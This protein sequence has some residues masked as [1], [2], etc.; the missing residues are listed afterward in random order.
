M[1]VKIR[2]HSTTGLYHVYHDG[3]RSEKPMPYHIAQEH[4]QR[5]DG[6][7]LTG[8]KKQARQVTPT[9]NVQPRV[10]QVHP[11]VVDPINQIHLN[12]EP[13]P[14]SAASASVTT[15]SEI[16]PINMPRL[17]KGGNYWHNGL[18]SSS[19]SISSIGSISVDQS[20]NST[21]R[22]NQRGSYPE[23]LNIPQPKQI[24]RKSSDEY[25]IKRN[26]HFKGSDDENS[27]NLPGAVLKSTSSKKKINGGALRM[28]SR[29]DLADGIHTIQRLYAQTSHMNFS[30]FRAFAAPYAEEIRMLRRL[31]LHSTGF[32]ELNGYYRQYFDFLTNHELADGTIFSD[33]VNMLLNPSLIGH[34]DD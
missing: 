24:T 4:K 17:P 9:I 32:S 22:R 13:D 28:P 23:H 20:P 2:K 6:G 19:N 8:C 18:S 15:E 31:L 10:I 5:I 27:I 29:N 11:P 7:C 33:A 16:K 1:S 30:Q 25:V 21:R 3:Y 12:F 34:L 14:L 26:Q